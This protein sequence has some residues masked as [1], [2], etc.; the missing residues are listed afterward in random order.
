M[1]NNKKSSLIKYLAITA[2]ACATTFVVIG[3]ATYHFVLSRKGLTGPIAKKVVNKDIDKIDADEF[4][5]KLEEIYRNGAK[6]FDEADKESISIYNREN[7][8]LHANLFKPK[9]ESNIYVFCIHGY[10]S[11]PRHM[12]IYVKEFLE[13]GYNV[14]TPSLRGH[15]ESEED[16]ISMGWND[17]LDVIDWIE[18][19]VKMHPDCKI[20]IHGVSMGAATTMMTIGEELPSNVKLA[21]EDCGYTNVWDIMKHKMAQMKVP[22]FPFLYSA[23]DVNR[24][25]AK[26]GFKEASCTEQL[27]NCK[28]PV[29]FIHGEND[30]F[31][32]YPML[33]IVYDACPT[34]KDMLSVPDAPHARSVCA[35]QE[36][37]WPKVKDFIKKY[38]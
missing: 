13:M 36:M 4:R 31:V 2:G 6:W 1:S 38:L 29:L 30:D 24:R 14:I 23:S 16:F 9:K 27:K 28:I 7:N 10:S 25:K 20:I 15:A 8:M 11:S 17:R 18:Y 26:F 19:T 33:Q 21:I 5:H 3:E 22:E 37:Y 12:G 32:P 34:E 35:H